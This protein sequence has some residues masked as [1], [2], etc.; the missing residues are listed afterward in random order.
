MELTRVFEEDF[1]P[2]KEVGAPDH[3]LGVNVAFHWTKENINLRFSSKTHIENVIPKFKKLLNGTLNPIKTPMEK[4]TIQKMMIFI[5]SMMMM[6]P[7]V[8]ES[9]AT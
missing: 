3:C 8:D 5:C 1:H 7:N 2:T 4:L 6:H 9:L